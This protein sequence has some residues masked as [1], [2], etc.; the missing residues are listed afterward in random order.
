MFD[1]LVNAFVPDE[2]QVLNRAHVE[3][4]PIAFV[5][6][7][8][9]LTWEVITL[10]AVLYLIFRDEFTFLLD[11][12][13]ILVLDSTSGA[14]IFSL[15]SIHSISEVCHTDGTVHTAR[16]N[17]LLSHNLLTCILWS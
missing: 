17:K 14:G 13:T 12:G 16:R 3:S 10:E 1:E 4:G 9:L 6:L 8:Y 5:K 15:A 11:K 7:P 2:L